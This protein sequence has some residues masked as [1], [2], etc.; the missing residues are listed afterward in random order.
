MLQLDGDGNPLCTKQSKEAQAL[1][2][3][4]KTIHCRPARCLGTKRGTC[5]PLPRGEGRMDVRGRLSELAVK[6]RGGRPR[7][8]N[9]GEAQGLV[10]GAHLFTSV[11]F[12]C[13]LGGRVQPIEARH[14]A[15]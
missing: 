4:S 5:R 9:R 3:G 8:A 6:L 2:L 1:K 7:A 15:L 12:A 14:R 11:L 13:V 10:I